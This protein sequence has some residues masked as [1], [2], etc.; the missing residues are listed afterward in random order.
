MRELLKGTGGSSQRL[1]A[2]KGK[3]EKLTRA[4]PPATIRPRAETPLAEAPLATY[5]MGLP[6]AVGALPTP[7]EPTVPVG[8]ETPEA[9]GTTMLGAAVLEQA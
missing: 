6:V 5:G 3:L 1:V 2:R 8:A 9:G 4:T 7:V